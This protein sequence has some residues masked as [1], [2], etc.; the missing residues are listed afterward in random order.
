MYSIQYHMNHLRR[1]L[2]ER[3]SLIEVAGTADAAAASFVA[4]VAIDHEKPW[5]WLV[6][7]RMLKLETEIAK[8]RMKIIN[9]SMKPGNERYFSKYCVGLM[10]D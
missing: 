3:R 5:S 1:L 8:T 9:L 2:S 6:V 4:G 10:S 7:D